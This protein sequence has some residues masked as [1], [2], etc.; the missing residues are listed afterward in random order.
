MSRTKRTWQRPALV[1]LVR[2]RPEETVLAACKGAIIEGPDTVHGKACNIK[3]I[4]CYAK[5][6]S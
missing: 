4:P 6:L 2:S 5:T 3:G 1:V